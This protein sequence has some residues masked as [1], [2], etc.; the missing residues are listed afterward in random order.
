MHFSLV[1]FQVG[2]P[3]ERGPTER[4]DKGASLEKERA[5]CKPKLSVERQGPGT[6]EFNP[7]L[8]IIIDWLILNLPEKNYGNMFQEISYPFDLHSGA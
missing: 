8:L 2:I 1:L 4:T 7:K 6:I 3:S 5:K